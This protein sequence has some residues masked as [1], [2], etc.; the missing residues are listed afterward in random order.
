MK[1]SPTDTNTRFCHC[2]N[3]IHATVYLLVISF[4]VG[5]Y[6]QQRWYL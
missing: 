3:Q 5:R 4:L 1:Y 2:F 6:I